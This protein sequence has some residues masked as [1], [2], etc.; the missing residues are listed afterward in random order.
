ML[1]V[2]LIESLLWLEPEPAK[3]TWSQSP[4]TDR[5]RNTAENTMLLNQ[6]ASATTVAEDPD[7]RRS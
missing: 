5:L 4:K 2:N 7:H 6:L 1:F 3:K